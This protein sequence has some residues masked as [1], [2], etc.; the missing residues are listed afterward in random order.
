VDALAKW[1]GSQEPNHAVRDCVPDNMRSQLTFFWGFNI[2][3]GTED[4]VFDE[5]A[6]QPL[7]A[8][9]YAEAM[10]WFST[11]PGFEPLHILDNYPWEAL[12]EAT[13]VDIGGSHGSISIALAQ[14]FPS[15]RC[16]VQDRPEVIAK[17][18]MAVPQNVSSR[19]SF[20]AHDFFTEQPITGA[21]VYY[22]RW[23]LHDWSDKYAIR[24][25]RA[26]IPALKPEARIVVSEY[27]LPDPG[28]L[29]PYQDRVFR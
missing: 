17:G 1:P 16:I 18:K 27:I 19:V 3:H 6:T 4:T 21:E 7:R 15:I 28:V 29:S 11:G 23:I 14:R 12:G 20:M 26:L 8:Q 9:R 22:F 10:S 13:V 25:L 2:A 24:I 5:F